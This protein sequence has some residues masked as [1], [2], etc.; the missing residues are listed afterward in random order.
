MAMNLADAAAVSGG[1]VA[2]VTGIDLSISSTD[3]EEGPYFG[4]RTTH[5][6]E[7]R[8][9]Q[10]VTLT[11][12]KNDQSWDFMYNGPC[13]DAH[14]SGS[15]VDAA[16][17]GPR[18]GCVSGA[19]SGA[20]LIG[21]GNYNPRFESTTGGQP[22]TGGDG[23]AGRSIFGYRLHV[24]LKNSVDGEV[25]TVRN[26]MITGHTVSLNADGTME[27]TMEYMS[28]VPPIFVS[29]ANTFDTTLTCPVTGM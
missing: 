28:N 17:M 1:R 29:G 4:Q 9:E 2:D 8:K 15:A 3:E 12:K 5:K 27:E 14:Y 13:D 26:A 10:S 25:Y 23:T 18:W 21:D 19:I 16:A 22:V 11:R 6:I 20:F 24:R 7:I